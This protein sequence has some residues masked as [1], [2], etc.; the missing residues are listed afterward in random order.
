MNRRDFLFSSIAAASS[1]AGGV[2]V[3]QTK[4]TQTQPGGFFTIG[5]RL[6]RWWFLRPDGNRFFSLGLNHVDP[7]TIRYPEN[8]QRWRDRY[9]NSMQRWL[10]DS[11]APNLADWGFNSLGWNQEVIT[12]GFT[13]HRHSRHF[14]REEYD[15]LG[16]PYCH[17]LPF[18]DF[19]QWEAETRN[20]DFFS[21][22]FAD[23]CDHVAREHCV[24]LSDD[25]NL[26]GYFYIDCPCWLHVRDI[27][28]WKGPLFDPQRLESDAGSAEL[29]KLATQYYKVTHDAV[30][31]YDPHHLILGD[32]YEANAPL[33][34]EIIN[35]ARP[36]VD[37]LSFQDF[38]DP[39]GHLDGWYAKTGMPVLWADGAHGVKLPNGDSRNNGKWYAEVLEGLQ[40]NPGCIGAHLCG[41]YYRNRVRRRGLLDENEQ[42]DKEMIDHIRKANTSTQAWV[43]DFGS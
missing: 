38:R 24:P 3:A 11:V 25:P 17:Q 9:G 34:M 37:V 23:W 41:A 4:T 35:A 36:F 29:T 42:P 13:N 10:Q 19:H 6:G 14:T 28:K 18:A 12:R 7:A 8:I 16:L 20:P 1:L 21:S 15:W 2:S 31:R 26:I 5:Q 33:T 30:R 40:N 32:R 43:T 22:G 39:V 27:N